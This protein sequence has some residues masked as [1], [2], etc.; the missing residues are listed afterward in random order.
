VAPR[1]ASYVHG[2]TP[3]RLARFGALLIILAVA[4]AAPGS[5]GPHDA[6]SRHPF[7]DVDHWTAVFDDPERDAWQKPD[8][9]VKALALEP[10]MTVADLGAG[11]G[12][13]SR[14]LSEAVGP[15]GTVF[16]VDPEPNLVAHLR[17][18]A[19]RE[20]T[21]N[22]VPVLA[23]SDN[24]RLPTGGVDLVLILDTYHHL[25]D[26]LRYLRDLARVLRPGGRVAVIDWHKRPLPV[27]PDLDHKL[28]REQVVAEM[29]AAGWALDSESDVLPYQYF[30]LFRRKP[31]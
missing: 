3:S 1:F 8:A 11:T 2:G 31:A 26:R 22:V 14:R 19:E 4:H 16:A 20:R 21:A 6:T 17:A 24:P 18:R 27:G 7:D 15:R 9:L 13:M 23:S 12:Y 10:G 28:A 25:D 30:L 29:T 5:A